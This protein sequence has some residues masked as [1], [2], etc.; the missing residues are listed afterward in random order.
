MDPNFPPALNIRPLE[1]PGVSHVPDNQQ[2]AIAQYGIAGRVWEASQPLIRY[3]TPQNQSF[4]EPPCPIFDHAGPKRIIELGSGQ[5]LASLHLAQ[6]LAP[7]DVLV[8]TDLPNVVPLCRHSADAWKQD[9]NHGAQVFVES[10]A[11]GEDIALVKGLGPFD[12]IVMC[13]L[14]GAAGGNGRSCRSTSHTCIR[15]CCAPCCSS[16][17][18][19]S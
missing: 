6:H 19:Q 1:L 8:L 12:Y 13:D 18:S 10:L 17:N 4:F 14:V 16:P 3:F 15:L 7:E 2:Q 11:W 9:H 5:A